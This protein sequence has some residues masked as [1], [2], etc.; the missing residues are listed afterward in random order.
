MRLC[1]LSSL[2]SLLLFVVQLAF[3]CLAAGCDPD[4]SINP[5]YRPQDVVYDATLIGNWQE[6]DSSNR[7]SLVVRARGPDSYTVE[8]TQNDKDK[9]EDTSWTFDAYVFNYQ[10]QTYIDLLPINFRVRGKNGRFQ[11]DANDLGFLVPVHTAMRLSHGGQSLSLSWTGGSEMS[12]FFKKEDDAAA[13]EKQLA[14][15][16]KQRAILVMST[17]QLQR[18]VL[19]APPEGNTAIEM[20]MHFVRKN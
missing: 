5:F 9:K 13:K 11:A 1:T 12:S 17:E 8:L 10:D 18:E 2:R 15:E 19:G 6:V 7:G 3:V 4:Q 14:R 16:R 20:G